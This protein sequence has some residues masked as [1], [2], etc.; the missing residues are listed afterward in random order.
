[1]AF[2][3]TVTAAMAKELSGALARGKI[4][5]VSQPSREELILH[6]HTR[7]GNRK[8]YATVNSEAAQVRLTDE[9]PLNP[10]SPPPFC[11]LMRKHLT[12]ARITSI[13]Q[14]GC[15]R[16]I[17]IT[18]ETRNELEFLESRRL[19][20]EIMGK[21]S[22]IIL[23]DAANGKI[24]DSIKHV[25]PGESRIRQVLPGLT[26][27]SPPP[28]DKVPFREA[29]PQD[30]NNAGETG[31][32]VLAKIGGISPAIAREIADSEDR[33]GFLEN[34]IASIDGGTFV[35]RVYVD[36]GGVPREFSV[37]PLTE[38][39]ETC[40]VLTFP[41]LSEAAAWYFENR[42]ATNRIHQKS[43]AL[44]RSVSLRL[45][46]L[47][48]KKQRL[49]EDL[50]EAE[51]SEYLRLYGELLTANM[52]LVTG[53]MSEITVLNYYNG[54]NVT[55]PLD[56][57][58]S[59][60]KNAQ[61]YFRRYGKAKTA[62]REKK[63]QIEENDRE[64]EYLSSVLALIE[65]TDEEKN[66]EELREELIETGYLRPAKNPGKVKK[67]RFKPEPLIFRSPGGFRVLVGRNN[68]ENDALTLGMAE[69]SDLWFHTKNIPGSHVILETCGN[70]VPAEDIYMAASLAAF[71]S[72]ARASANVPVDYTEVR[73]VK[74][75]SGAKPGM[76]IYK[77][78]HTVYVNPGEP[79]NSGKSAN[80]ESP[81]GSVKRER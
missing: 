61:Q 14:A 11:M 78:Q 74:K 81:G 76:V 13:S 39:E 31:K 66:L 69:K 71:H 67:S 28:Q 37:V 36:S 64:T 26:Y 17:E 22:N 38:Y 52:H 10:P 48:L 68:R 25:T 49:L 6:I 77:E 55:I 30:L 5:R 46:K 45:D 2:D 40:D 50:A 41:T 8:L 12:G 20:F 9:S 19:I 57:R 54:E 60:N 34:L 47:N 53:G 79:D 33:A 32:S 70:R 44:I 15:E 1:M 72:R 62:I 75:P 21:H 7:E 51:S 35:P 59:P 42:A 29:A 16:V 56:P 63:K 3:G 23:V 73:H 27:V 58:Y 24:I 80:Q 65:D 18:L 4:D 43:R